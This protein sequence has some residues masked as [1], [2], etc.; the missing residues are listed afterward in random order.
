MPEASPAGYEVTIHVNGRPLRVP[1]GQRLTTA[2]WRQGRRVLGRS[3][4]YHRARGLFC[5]TGE[6]THCFLRVDGVPNVRACQSLCHEGMWVE[7]QNAWPNARYDVLAAAD[8]AF[9]DYLDAHTSFIRPRILKP[10]YDKVI[11]GMAGFGKIPKKPVAQRYDARNIDADVLVVG[12]GPAGLAAAEA[13]SQAGA[14]VVLVE[15][16]GRLGG[17]LAW[18]RDPD[19]DGA[20]TRVWVAERRR[21]LESEGAEVHTRARLVGIYPDAGAVAATP[22]ALL[23]IQAERLV[24]ATGARDAYFP[25]PGSDRAGVLLATAAHRMLAE[26][27]TL[28]GRRPVILGATSHAVSLARDLRDAGADVAALWEPR[29]EAD[30]RAAARAAKEGIAVHADHRP[31]RAWGR[32]RFRRIRFQVP[33]GTAQ[34]EGDVLVMAHGRVARAE[35]GQQAGCRLVWRDGYAF[36][37]EADGEGATA[38][39]HVFAAGSA[40]GTSGWRAAADQ[41]RRAGRRAAA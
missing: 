10:V 39:D 32:T 37:I 11:R 12:A 5:G 8:V 9:P 28:A 19:G 3:M 22:T 31:E 1:R 16:T 2:L 29:A 24:V 35:L 13:A 15:R 36:T 26:E 38:R 18:D 21:A 30:G 27:G 41:G 6:C 40:A 25:F 20:D 33:G 23:R 4:R 34:A 7:D 14:Q 17:R